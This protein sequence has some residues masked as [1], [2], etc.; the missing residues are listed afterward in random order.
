[1]KTPSVNVQTADGR[2]VYIAAA[3]S[4][5]DK[6]GLRLDHERGTAARHDG[7]AARNRRGHDLAGLDSPWTEPGPG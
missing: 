1:M 5:D 3:N 4:T 2:V 6:V 7:G